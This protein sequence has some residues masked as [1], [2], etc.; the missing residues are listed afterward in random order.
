MTNPFAHGPGW[1][2]VAGIAGLVIGLGLFLL[3]VWH[4]VRRVADV[5]RVPLGPGT[6][7]FLFL[8]CLV[9]IG[10]GG[11]A[12]AVAAAH[13]DWAPRA[14]APLPTTIAEMTCRPEGK[15]KARLGL[16]RVRLDGQRA[17]EEWQI[18]DGGECAIL[19]EVLTFPAAL[20][21]VGLRG[22][23]RLTKVGERP[24]PVVTPAWRALPRP[25]GVPVA[26]ATAV[27]VKAASDRHAIQRVVLD[28]PS[29]RLEAVK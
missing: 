5:P 21:K 10:F 23:Y 15:G 17:G 28:G 7:T 12:L 24:D 13:A 1:M 3:L 6:Y 22:R 2:V 4:I 25:G 9:A 20:E 14:P 29:L 11:L 26:T 27:E 16:V 18:V 19:G 8:A